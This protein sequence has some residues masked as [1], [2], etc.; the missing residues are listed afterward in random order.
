MYKLYERA[1]VCYAYLSDVPSA[2]DDHH[3]H[4]SALRRSRWFTR[5]WTLQELLAPARVEFYSRDWEEIGTKRSMPRLLEEI[6]QLKI[7]CIAP[8]LYKD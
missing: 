1:Q 4:N 7:T 8:L 2:L 3:E 5:G 6:C